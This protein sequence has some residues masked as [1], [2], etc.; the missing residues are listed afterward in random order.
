MF[1]FA[2][3]MT[4][5]QIG[6]I[7]QRFGLT[8]VAQDTIGMLGRPVYTLR[9]AN[10]QS[11][12]EVIHRIEAAGLPVAVQP[13]YAY[14][15]TQDNNSNADLGNPGQYIADKFHFAEVHRITK[16]DKA[17]VAVINSE[18]NSNQPNLAGTVTH[19]YDAGCNASSPHPHGTGMAG[20]IAST[21]SC[22]GSPRK[23]TS[24]RFAPSAVPASP[25][26]AR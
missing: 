26:R 16:G 23:Q 17:V 3:G 6:D 20:A 22:W 5:Q 25:K 14:R 24:S 7:V 8:I 21:D 4:P 11:V 9:I 1:Q 19:R 13:K 18:I 10:G 12:R 15:L 2:F